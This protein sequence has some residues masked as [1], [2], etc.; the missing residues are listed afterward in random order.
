MAR[1]L[2]ESHLTVLA[3]HPAFIR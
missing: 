2:E 3:A 1:V